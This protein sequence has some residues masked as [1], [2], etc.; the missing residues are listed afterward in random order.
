MITVKQVLQDKKHREVWSLTPEST[1]YDALK[2]MSEKGV[3]ALPVIEADK[4]VGI[5]SE[6]DY[7]RKVILKG[8]SSL[9]TP[10]REIMTKKVITVHPDQTM[11]ECMELMTIKRVRHLPV[12]L[13]DQLVG[14]VSIGDVLKEI[15]SEQE[16]FIHDLQN[17][18]EGR[19]Y[20]SSGV[21]TPATEATS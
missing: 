18:I 7:A 1:V 10:I 3:G 15:I 6:R 11:Q 21:S 8:R 16:L 20:G 13:G 2:L 9:K 5:M 4:L 14:L 17:Y 19:G 12:L